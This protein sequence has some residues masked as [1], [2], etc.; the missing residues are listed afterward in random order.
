MPSPN[1]SAGKFLPIVVLSPSC[2]KLFD[3]HR[4]SFETVVGSGVGV[5]CVLLGVGVGDKLLEGDGVGVGVPKLPK[6]PKAPPNPNPAAAFNQV[7][8]Y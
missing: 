5:G 8:P 4:N 6:V 7:L 2:P 1:T 3:P